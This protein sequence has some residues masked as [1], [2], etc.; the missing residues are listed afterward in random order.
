MTRA[1]AVLA[2]SALLVAA[3]SHSDDHADVAKAVGNAMQMGT[4]KAGLPPL[5]AGDALIVTEDGGIDLALVGDT[6]SSGLSQQTL[7]KARQETD[8]AAVKG[9]GLGSFIEKTV[10]SSVQGALGTRV[11]FPLSEVKDARYT[12]GRIE[13]DWNGKEPGAFYGAKV[14]GK[15]LMESFS[16]AEAQRFV[17]AVNARKRGGAR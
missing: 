10:K 13:F 8:T 7:A 6:V 11:T 14:N 9:S 5:K 3:C 16:P 1:F 4:T 17:D 2:T 15:P 12:N